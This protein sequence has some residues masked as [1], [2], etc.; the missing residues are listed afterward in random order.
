MKKITQFLMM[1]VAMLCATAA[2]SQSTVKGKIMDA[3]MNAPLPGANVVEKGTTNGTTTN[4]DGE[5]T[6]TTQASSGS[7]VIS[8]VGFG[9]KTI[10]FTGSQDLGTINLL[11]DNSLDEIVIVGSGLI[12]LADDRRTPIAVSTVRA[13]EIQAKVGTSDVTATLVNTPSVYVAGQSS[14][15]G[16]SRISVRGFEQDNTAFLLNGQPINGMED[17]KMYWSNWSGMS[18]IA[19]AIQI[20]RGLG[21]SKLAISSV[22]GT[23]NFVTKATDRR[24]GGFISTGVANNDYLKSTVGYSSGMTESGWGVTAML[25]HWQGDGYNLGTSGEGQNYFVSVGYKANDNHNF[26]FLITGA[27]QTH[28]QNFSKSIST[29]LE[30]G[31]KYNDN[32]GSYKGQYLTERTNYYHKPV[33]NLNWDWNINDNSSLSTVLYASW[34]RGGGTGNYGSSRNRVRDAETGLIDFDAIAANNKEKGEG[35]FANGGYLLRASANNHNW[36]GAVSNFETKLSEN[37]TLNAGLDLRTYYGTHYRQVVNFLGLNSWKDQVKL[38][39]QNHRASGVEVDRIIDQDYSINPWYATFN[40][41]DEDQRIDYDYSERINYGG[42]FTQVEYANDAFSVF[43]QGSVSNQTHEREDRYDYLTEF[44]DAEK[45]T[46]FGYNLKTGGSFLINDDNS[47]Y[48]NAGY[49]SRQPYHDNIY[50]NYTNE[51]NPLTENEKILGLE[52]GYAFKSQFFTANLN[53]YRTSWKDRVTTNSSVLSKD[54]EIGG[55]VIPAGTVVFETNEGVEQLHSGVELDVV[56]KIGDKL[57]LKGFTSIGDWKYVGDVFTTSRD[58]SRNV[59]DR[60]AKDVDGGKVGDAAQ[61]TVGLGLDY[62]IFER[63]SIDADWRSY[64]KLYA[65][66]SPDKDN[67]ELPA[68]DIMDMGLSYKMLVG[69]EQSNSVN[70]RLNVNNVFGEVYLS[71]IRGRTLYRAEAGDETYK[72]I[73]VKNEAYFGYGRT[74]NF[75]VRYNF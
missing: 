46:N 44:K 10:T 1:S 20:Q 40:A 65:N 41:A 5:F 72:G 13:S 6:L 9:S 15:F 45:V 53:L 19:N 7:L 34:G 49:Y 33:A 64:D 35:A 69:K 38:N 4:F 54:K 39:G 31:R 2:F 18:D 23:V 51:V 14:G 22:G 74:W 70:L 37:V 36:Y 75:S 29:Y 59:L 27:P 8:Y 60:E 21:S 28:D 3:D 67:L 50:L 42:A 47:V 16:D 43:F 11:T 57:K 26:N 55:N 62:E 12:D 68:F 63:F 30:R 71:E 32:Y 61:F 17:G 24:Q 25:T 58:E 56:A 66:V 73:N 52:A 48:V